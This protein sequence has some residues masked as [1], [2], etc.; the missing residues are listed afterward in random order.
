MSSLENLTDRQRA[1]FEFIR[2]LIQ[3]RGYGPTVREVCEKFNIRSPNGVMCHLKALERKGVISREKG[4]SR[5]IQL[6]PEFVTPKQNV[7][8][9]N[10]EF[11]L[12]GV[13]SAGFTQLAEESPDR[14]N[15]AEAF[16][17]DDSFVL[18]V[19]GDS[20]IE[21]HIE[22]GDY[23]ICKRQDTAEKGQIVVALNDEGEATLKYWYPEPE[24]NRIRLQPANSQMQP[25]YLKDAQVQAVVVGV[26]RTRM[27]KAA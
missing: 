22:Q 13:V 18:E 7:E 27:G 16:D 2:D 17:K 12:L 3:Q 19:K 14:I 20:M 1:V 15:F 24:N 26:I 25:I 8:I 10:A 5:A 4:K 9:H 23:V 6:S 21:A 11:D